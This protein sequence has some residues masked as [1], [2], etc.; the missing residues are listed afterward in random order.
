MTEARPSRQRS[1]WVQVVLVS[2]MTTLSLLFGLVAVFLVGMG[3]YKFSASGGIAPGRAYE[4]GES[5]IVFALAAVPA[6]LSLLCLFGVYF[7]FDPTKPAAKRTMLI[8]CLVTVLL[9]VASSYL[10]TEEPL[11][12]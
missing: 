6:V 1:R 9:G 4:S 3:G 11:A 12:P 2:V 10:L 8:A 7:S 5:E